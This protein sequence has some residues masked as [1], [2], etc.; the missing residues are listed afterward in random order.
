MKRMHGTNAQY[1]SVK[2]DSTKATQ[3]G[4]SVYAKLADGSV[5]PAK[6]A[7]FRLFYYGTK[8]FKDGKMVFDGRIGQSPITTKHGILF[9]QD[10][11]TAVELLVDAPENFSVKI[12]TGKEPSFE[13]KNVDPNGD[14]YWELAQDKTKR[15]MIVDSKDGQFTCLGAFDENSDTIVYPKPITVIEPHSNIVDAQDQIIQWYADNGTLYYDED[16]G[17]NYV[18]LK[19]EIGGQATWE[20]SSSNKQI[21]VSD[22]IYPPVITHKPHYELYIIPADVVSFPA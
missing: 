21:L 4:I 2:F 14:E 22:F 6:E 20:I 17:D 7:D 11:S 13:I 12:A 1:L 5:V 9:D 8:S 16:D 3:L 18:R 19:K 10:V 15:V